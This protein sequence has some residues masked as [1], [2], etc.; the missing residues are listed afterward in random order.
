[1]IP[2]EKTVSRPAAA[3]RSVARTSARRS[4]GTLNSTIV[5]NTFS[6]RMSL[7]RAPLV[8]SSIRLVSGLCSSNEC[9]GGRPPW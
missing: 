8:R 4:S 2:K 6:F 7:L 3:C 1:M 5:D 9:P